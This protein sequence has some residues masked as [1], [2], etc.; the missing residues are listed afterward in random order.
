VVRRDLTVTYRL[1]GSSVSSDD[2]GLASQDNTRFDL[3]VRPGTVVRAGT[4]LGRLVPVPGLVRALRSEAV[5][6]TVARSQLD[7]LERRVGSVRAP[8]GGRL[9][10]SGS[11][12]AIASAGLDAVVPITPLQELRYRSLTFTGTVTLETVFGQRSAPCVSVWLESAGPTAST[13]DPAA[14]QS[15][16]AELHCRIPADVET[17]PGLPL[18]VA[19]TSPTMNDLLA[20]PAIY[21]G[22]DS[23][24]RN[25]VVRVRKAGHWVAKPV[26]VGPSD[27]VVRVIEAGLSEGDVLTTF[28]GSW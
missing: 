6:S 23:Q 10:R 5:T 22:L 2:V 12:L 9:V 13:G 20:V 16:Q 19:L 3:V 17:A 7:A 4:T 18:T 15:S 1:E 21:V 27:G 28:A 26:V 8:L 11:R 14:D 24:G 25:Y